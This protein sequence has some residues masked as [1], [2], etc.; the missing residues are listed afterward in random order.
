MDQNLDKLWEEDLPPL[1]M[2]IKQVIVKRC[3]IQRGARTK[4]RSCDHHGVWWNLHTDV[5]TI[6]DPELT[7]LMPSRA[8]FDPTEGL[9]LA[10]YTSSTIPIQGRPFGD[11]PTYVTIVEPNPSQVL[12]YDMNVRLF[13]DQIPSSNGIAF[14]ILFGQQQYDQLIIN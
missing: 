12:E 14:V 9:M 8:W 4:L 13:I 1:T 3:K 7:G 6:D 2:K 10:F 5:Y 11:G